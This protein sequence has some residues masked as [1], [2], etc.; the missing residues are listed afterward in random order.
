MT[1]T[2]FH[3]LRGRYLPNVTVQD[4]REAHRSLGRLSSAVICREPTDA[5]DEARSVERSLSLRRVQVA[6]SLLMEGCRRHDAGYTDK[7]LRYVDLRRRGDSAVIVEAIVA[8]LK[9]LQFCPSFE[10]ETASAILDAF[11]AE[12][13]NLR[14]AGPILGEAMAKD[15]QV[16]LGV[17]E[18]T[19]AEPAATVMREL[20]DIASRRD[21]ALARKRAKVEQ[22]A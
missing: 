5:A 13:L 2:T 16:G 17:L 12:G 10:E 11:W 4:L 6:V 21:E 15:I 8:T 1:C 3:A 22:E 20:L 9:N 18:A 14:G 19:G 7:G